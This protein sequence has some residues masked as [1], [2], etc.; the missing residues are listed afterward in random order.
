[1]APRADKA[2]GVTSAIGP[3]ALRFARIMRVSSIKKLP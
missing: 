3:E 2:D 1:M